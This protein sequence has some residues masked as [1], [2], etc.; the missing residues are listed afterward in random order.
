MNKFFRDLQ[1]TAHYMFVAQWQNDNLAVTSHSLP[2]HHT[3]I[4]RDSH[5]ASHTA[6][7]KASRR[8]IQNFTHP[9]HSHQIFCQL[10][11][12][13]G[14]KNAELLM[15]KETKYSLAELLKQNNPIKDDDLACPG[16][17]P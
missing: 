15:T 5:T 2:K 8:L 7:H 11:V 16:L 13:I 3:W 1:E 4:H 12:Y 10:P 6:S 9:A 14:R 17:P